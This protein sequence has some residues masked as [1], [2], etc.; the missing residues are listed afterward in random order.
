M[1]SLKFAKVDFMRNRRQVRLTLL[2]V[3][4]ALYF[5]HSD[6]A[7]GYLAGLLYLVFM[8]NVFCNVIFVNTGMQGTGFVLLLPGSVRH[9]IC[10]R[11]LYGAV[12]LSATVVVY[13]IA[14]L[15]TG[16]GHI[17]SKQGIFLCLMALFIGIMVNNIEF[18]LF[19]LFGESKSQMTMSL[20]RILPP[21]CCFFIGFSI[22]N[23]LESMVGA[24]E[25][26]LNILLWIESHLALCTAI[27]FGLTIIIT[28][29][30]I[31]LSTAI[32]ERRD[33]A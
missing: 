18:V 24:S 29:V 25:M 28:C 23:N 2:L 32:S 12:F 19:Y 1:R 13:W 5:G 16:I 31:L 6:K 27:L 14:A 22:I 7:T 8:V 4:I 26:L 9:R 3:A 20:L 15:L 17:L 21:L 33:F 11:F 30:C 10:G